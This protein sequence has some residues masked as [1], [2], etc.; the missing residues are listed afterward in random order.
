MNSSPKVKT[1]QNSAN[2]AQCTA[3][4]ARFQDECGEQQ[5]GGADDER[6]GRHAPRGHERRPPLHVCR[7]Q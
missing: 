1:T 3:T 4:S 2:Q 7:R 5:I 6:A